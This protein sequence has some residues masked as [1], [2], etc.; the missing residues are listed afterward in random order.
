MDS[1]KGRLQTEGKA[2]NETVAG[3]LVVE[4]GQLLQ[5]VAQLVLAQLLAQEGHC[6]R[7]LLLADLQGHQKSKLDSADV[8]TK[9]GRQ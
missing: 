4:G 6:R 5:Q 7:Q 8:K 1:A 3:A 9:G 2:L